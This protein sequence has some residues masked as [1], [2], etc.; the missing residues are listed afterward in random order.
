MTKQIS[1]YISFLVPFLFFS[2]KSS[3]TIKEVIPL[4][5]QKELEFQEKDQYFT[6]F[7]NIES[8]MKGEKIEVTD[9]R[10]FKFDKILND[11][12]LI[13]LGLCEII[14]VDN[15]TDIHL[16]IGN[17][18]FLI[19]SLTFYKFSYLVLSKNDK[20]ITLKYTNQ[21]KLYY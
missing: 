2:C 12:S 15:T 18:S 6:F 17:K 14:E 3:K 21:T 5:E 1:L 4:S 13:N 11:C 16:K 8:S 19:Q 7:I 20:K 9:D 10:K